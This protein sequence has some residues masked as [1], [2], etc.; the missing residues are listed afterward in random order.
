M[1]LSF[2]T[3]LLLHH[4]LALPP[5]DIGVPQMTAET[6]SLCCLSLSLP[7][8]PPKKAQNESNCPGQQRGALF[9]PF[10][11]VHP[12]KTDSA[13]K[14]MAGSPQKFLPSPAV[15]GERT[16]EEK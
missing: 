2:P 6:P 13:A 8:S 16:Q 12:P 4:S 9:K 15:T 1:T 10:P 11:Q 3:H 5:R 7:S 14:R